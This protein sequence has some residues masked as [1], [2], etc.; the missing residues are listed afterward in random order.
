MNTFMVALLL[1]LWSGVAMV[2]N[3]SGL[4]VRTALL[5]G[6]IAGL[7]VG[8]VNL[9]FQIG[10]QCLLLSVGYYTYGGATVPDYVTGSMFGV[11]VA[12]ATGSFD[13]G[14]TVAIALET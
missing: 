5:S 14:L 11:V 2:L 7:C 8:D 6:V 13:V 10:A 9:G 12:K 3:L 1:G 4:G